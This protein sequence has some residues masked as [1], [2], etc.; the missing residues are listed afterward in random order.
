MTVPEPSASATA[1]TDDGSR[2]PRLEVPFG[3]RVAA[4][5]SVCFV[6]IVLGLV[7]LI[8]LLN[9]ISLVTVTMAVAVMIT[10][11]LEPLVRLL[12]RAGVPRAL[13]GVGVFVLG[14]AGL[15]VAVWFVVSQ[16]TDS[17]G[18]I[19][20][21]LNQAADDIR[22]WLITGPLHLSAHDVDEYTTDLGDTIS[23]HRSTIVNGF[24]Q[25]ATSAVGVLSGAVLCLFA[26]L[27]L[28]LDDGRIW[29]WFVRIFPVH[30]RAHANEGG[31]A[32]W[33]TLTVYMRSLV[34]LAALNSLAMVPVMMIAGMPLVVPM[35][36]LLFLGSLVP[37]IGVLVAG[38]VV[39][40]IALVA[41]GL[42]TAIVMA[43]ALIL[44]VQLFGNLVNPIILGKAVDI[45]PLAIL[46]CVTGGTILAGIFGAFVAVP[47]VAVINNVVHAVR[48]QHRSS[49]GVVREQ[50][51]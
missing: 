1:G 20:T 31:V 26:T 35:A 38:V 23:S 39:C 5:W 51:A 10:A 36:V 40:L 3:V 32:A 7:V 2:D 37:L 44:V 14:I 9:S 4:W 46:V 45:H 21:Q 25:T 18:D 30:A 8:R 42:T 6:A 43:V 27:F 50:E 17:A 24:L 22:N 15:A 34:L 48:R 49:T 16:V 33:R 29:R 13:A 11:L 28:V 19:Q 41:S 47:L 12:V